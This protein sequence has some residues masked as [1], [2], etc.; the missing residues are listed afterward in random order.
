MKTY[1]YTLN[2]QQLAIRIDEKQGAVADIL[3]DG[4]HPAVPEAEMPAYAAVIALA[5]LER[6]VE[7]VHDEETDVITLASHLS[8]WGDLAS[9][10]A[11][12]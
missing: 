5:L 2:G 8:N 12:Q 10:L 6:E 1:N 11:Q 7:I 3:L 4:A 9:R